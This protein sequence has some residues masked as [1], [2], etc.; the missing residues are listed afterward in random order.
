MPPVSRPWRPPE[1]GLISIKDA[2]SIPSIMPQNEAK[3]MKMPTEAFLVS[4]AV[5]AMFVVFAAALM[6]ADHQ[7]RDLRPG[8][9]R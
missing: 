7:T 6:W 9:G 3:G 1:P 5:V 2:G 8:A 4:V